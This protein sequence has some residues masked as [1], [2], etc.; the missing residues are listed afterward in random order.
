MKVILEMAKTHEGDMTQAKQLIKEA[1]GLGVYAVK[2]QAYDLEDLNKK[3]G[4]YDR[5]KNCHLTLEQLNELKKFANFVGLEF[6]CSVFSRSLIKPLSMFTDTI[7]IPSTFFVYDDFVHDCIHYYDN[8]HISTG[9]HYTRVINNRLEEYRKN[10]INLVPYHCVSEYPTI[11]PCLNRI[12]DIGARGFSY[13]GSNELT[14]L[15][16]Q[17]MGCEYL[18]IHYS[19]WETGLVDLMKRMRKMKPLFYSSGTPSAEENTNFEFYRSEYLDLEKHVK[20]RMSNK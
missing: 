19:D 14:V 20:S 2:F 9:M 6:W 7:K 13:H 8:V 3:H 12:K 16:A 18:E 1:A 11:F 15:M 17:A 4:N 10:C 5:Y